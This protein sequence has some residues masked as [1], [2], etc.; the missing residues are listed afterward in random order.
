MYRASFFA[1]SCYNIDM[2]T[3]K[4]ILIL[5]CSLGL[6]LYFTNTTSAQTVSDNHFVSGDILVVNG[7]YEKDVYIF[8][9]EV[10]VDA[11]V[12]GDLF[13]AGQKVNIKGKV[14]GNLY[15]ASNEAVIDAH[16]TGS[17]RGAFTIGSLK[18]SVGRNITI[19]GTNIVS[20]VRVGWHAAFLGKNL[21]LYG[22]AG[23]W[24]I[25]GEYVSF[26]GKST[27]DVHLKNLNKNG[28]SQIMSETRID[29]ILY[30]SGDTMLDKKEGAEIL[31]DTVIQ[32][33][34][35]PSQPDYGYSQI[36]WWLV[37]VFGMM[38]VGLIIISLLGKK[39]SIITDLYSTQKFSSIGSGLLILFLTPIVCGV[40]LFTLIGIPLSIFLFILYVL[41]FY[42]SQIFVSI[43][44]GGVLLERFSSKPKLTIVNKNY[45]FW[46]LVVG[47]IVW[48]LLVQIPIVGELFI[49]FAFIVTISSLVYIYKSNIK[50][51]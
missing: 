48:R 43:W 22:S 36:F 14:G 7:N 29:G 23:R 51:V 19:I 12:G 31:G 20:D 47:V 5:L 41:S 4:K 6:F 16:V 28:Q 11:E 40:L 42:I 30:Y 46:C 27:G 8:G 25:E 44:L 34:Q 13:V 45:L 17:V 38:V 24:D 37:Y 26:S 15:V 33:Y 10:N 2:R 32:T 50:S 49:I 21:Q 9:N 39:I 18:G 3:K 1:L 35:R